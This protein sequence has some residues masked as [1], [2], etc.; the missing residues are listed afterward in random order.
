MALSP[1]ICEGLLR[2]LCI[3]SI[4][5]KDRSYSYRLPLYSV[6]WADILNITWMD[7]AP[8][9]LLVKKQSTQQTYTFLLMHGSH[10]E[11]LITQLKE[12][13]SGTSHLS[14]ICSQ[15][16]VHIKHLVEDCYCS[17]K[18]GR[19]GG[20]YSPLTPYFPKLKKLEAQHK[21]VPMQPISSELQKCRN[22]LRLI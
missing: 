5:F 13:L 9:R 18:Q 19:K 3:S 14:P 10:L 16:G 21:R 6:V 2:F 17:L 7:H 12:F 15:C 1:S 11:R 22:K 20:G 8:I 4:L